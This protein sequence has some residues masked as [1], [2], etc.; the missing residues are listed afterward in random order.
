MKRTIQSCSVKNTTLIVIRIIVQNIT[1][2][3]L[4][5][6]PI[7]WSPCRYRNRS[8]YFNNLLELVIT[9]PQNKSFIATS[10]QEADIKVW[11]GANS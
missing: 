8:L 2:G 11:Q 4:E 10:A 3:V 6:K 5:S 7:Q 9:L 1:V